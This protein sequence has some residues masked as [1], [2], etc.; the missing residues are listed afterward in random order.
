MRVKSFGRNRARRR[1][2]PR[3]TPT[4]RFPWNSTGGGF[5]RGTRRSGRGDR[6]AHPGHE[7]GVE[8]EVVGA[9]QGGGDPFPGPEQVVQPGS[10]VVAAGE[11]RALLVEPG[12]V[13]PVGGA[14]HVQPAGGG[15][16]DAAAGE[17]RGN[18]AV[19][20]IDA[21]AGRLDQIRREAGPHEIPGPLLAENFRGER[22]HPA[23]VPGRF[24]HQQAADAETVEPFSR[25]TEGEEG[26]GVF[27]PH[28]RNGASLDD[29]EEELTRSAWR[30]QRALGP[31]Q[32]ARRRPFDFVRRGRKRETFVEH[33]RDVRTEVPLDFDCPFRSQLVR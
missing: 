21:E 19:E 32:A 24:S 9:E 16:D 26:P 6:L 13:V 5:P 7:S 29:A 4:P 22:G 25:R 31:T 11:A 14:R 3:A 12:R 18:H 15:E 1:G 20:Q 23:G 33:H 27:A 10:A 28:V 30:R 8:R 2:E 17:P